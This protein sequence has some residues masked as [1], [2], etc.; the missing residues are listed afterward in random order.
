NDSFKVVIGKLPSANDPVD[1][2]D[3]EA[4]IAEGDKVATD[5]AV[6]LADETKVPV[7]ADDQAAL[8]K[9]LK[10]AKDVDQKSDATPE[11]VAQAKKD[12]DDVLNSIKDKANQASAQPTD[13]QVTKNAEGKPAVTGKAPAGSTVEV[14][15]KDGNVIGT[16]TA[17]ENG[18]FTMEVPADKTADLAVTAQEPGKKAS[19]AVNAV[20]KTGLENSI[21]EGDKV[22]TDKAVTLADGTKVP[23]TAADQDALDKALE[24]AKNVDQNASATP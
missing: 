6:T 9:A 19:E 4:S 16:T 15:D 3:L 18:N 1:K 21:A 20:D 24:A 14:K 5:K 22:A 13:V 17:D 12:L 10:A 11:E 2:T 23:V 7:T 8:D